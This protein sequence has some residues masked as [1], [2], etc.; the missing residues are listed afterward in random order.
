MST[1]TSKM[2]GRSVGQQ[3]RKARQG[4]VHIVLRRLYDLIF[5]EVYIQ[6]A[7]SRPEVQAAFAALG[8][9]KGLPP[10]RPREKEADVLY[11]L[12][13]WLL[14]RDH[15]GGNPFSYVPFLAAH[16]A[17]FG[18]ATLPPQKSHE[19]VQHSAP[20]KVGTAPLHDLT[21]NKVFQKNVYDNLST[22][23]HN[24]EHDRATVTVIRKCHNNPNA[25]VTVYRAVPAWAAYRAELAGI[26]PIAPGD[27][28]TLARGYAQ[29]HARGTTG[30][31]KRVVVHKQVRA[32]DVF[33]NGNDL[34]EWGYNP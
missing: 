22:L 24:P 25:R 18:A 6:D 7:R 32:A 31:G 13:K 28:V 9:A 10:R 27:W 26:I 5:E 3:N 29:E 11:S 16:V 20:G 4:T 23:G 1:T 8:N 34:D 30:A 14:G 15:Q 12:L 19:R 21:I 33:T 17:L 2:L